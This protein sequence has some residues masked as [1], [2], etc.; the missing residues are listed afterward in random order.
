VRFVERP[1]HTFLR[2]RLELYVRELDADVDDRL[3]VTLGGLD[4][5][6]VGEQLVQGLLAGTDERTVA[7]AEIARGS[8]P[9]VLLGRPVIDNVMPLAREIVAAVPPDASTVLDVRVPLRDGRTLRGTVAGLAGD[10]LVRVGF[11]R[12]RARQRIGTWVR[13][14]ALTAAH[15]GREFDAL[16]A[17]RADGGSGFITPR[18]PPVDG[19][20]ALDHLEAL[21]D[22]YHRGMREPPPLYPET[23]LAYA[24][25]RRAGD[26]AL[27]AARGAWETSFNF[28]NE[29]L[30]E[31]HL[32]VLGRKLSFDEL[33]AE[34]ARTDEHWELDEPRRVG[35]WAMRLWAPLLG[36]LA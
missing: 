33:F 31:A 7:L 4:T 14:L 27:A 6:K 36:H 1:V 32:L 8:L 18:I 3:P 9:P 12:V 26:D 28:P 22:L 19:A 20:E 30:D 5:Y 23:S 35:R 10:T 24:R 16:I 25:A 34:P 15:P 2:R 17:G 21:L 13:L 29:D 11:A